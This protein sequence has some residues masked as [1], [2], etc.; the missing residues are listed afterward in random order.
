MRVFSTPGQRAARELM[1]VE[2]SFLMRVCEN[3]TKFFICRCRHVVSSQ[4][5]RMV[6]SQRGS[7]GIIPRQ[8]RPRELES[9][10]EPT[11]S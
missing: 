5:N 9:T 8:L 4:E 6:E 3:F 11:Y 7:H 10:H 1:R 2:K